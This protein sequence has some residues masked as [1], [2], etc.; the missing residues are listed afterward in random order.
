M[1]TP[2]FLTVACLASVA[3]LLVADRRRLTALRVAAK[4]AASTSFVSVALSLGA[5][6]SLYGRFVLGALILGWIGDALLLSRAPKAF[7]GGLTAFLLSHLL[8]ATAFASGRLSAPAMGITAILSVIFGAIVLRWLL[9]HTPA[10]FKAPVL[11]YVVIILGMC[12]AAAGHT[13]ASERWGVLLG[14]VLFAASDLSVARD[15]FVRNA[16]V[17][18]LWGWPTYFVA[19]LVLAWSLLGIAS[20]A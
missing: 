1:L 20:A 2:L 8:F 12:V 6:S 18:R 14:A 10:G 17:N 16:Y 7:M 3:L 5:L 9:P 13:F 11:A 15:R 19:Q 4:L